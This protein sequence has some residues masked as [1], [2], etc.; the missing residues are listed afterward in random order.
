M[1]S[2]AQVVLKL[3]A[4]GVPDFYQG[5]E[6]WDLSLVDPDNRRAVDF[7]ARR[8]LLDELEP[9]I[10]G[11]LPAARRAEY[12]RELLEHW[13]DG[14]IKLYVTACGLRLRREQSVLFLDGS[15]LPLEITGERAPHAVAF[16]RSVGD[17]VA[18][19]VVPHLVAGLAG[20][21]PP[22]G[23]AAW[24]D[25]VVQLPDSSADR[26]FQ[27]VFTGGV[28]QPTHSAR[29][30]SLRLA[31]VLADLPVALLTARST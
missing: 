11:D 19:A 16:A 5:S 14:R 6:L 8:L 20:G 17:A 9:L 23:L 13:P 21:A 29:G 4:P 2:L 31:G 24:G 12:A 15:Y 10:G 30:A 26:E 25:T 28:L 1:N 7:D 22:L 27:D 3:A 18:V